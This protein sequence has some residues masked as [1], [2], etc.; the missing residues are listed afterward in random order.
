MMEPA[1]MNLF[2]SVNKQ[3]NVKKLTVNVFACVVEFPS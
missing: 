1:P 2:V 3:Q